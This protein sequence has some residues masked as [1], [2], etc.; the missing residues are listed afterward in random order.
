MA[1]AHL[2]VERDG[3]VLTITINRPRV[4]NALSADAIRELDRVMADA[5]ADASV[6]AVVLTGAGDRA[7]AAGADLRELSAYTP[8]QARDHAREVQAIFTRIERLGTPVIAAVNGLALGG[9]CE[10]A[11]SCAIRIA[12]E[13]AAFGQPEIN[14]AI[15][16]GYGGSSRLPRLVGRGAALDMLLTGE[17]IGARRAY[18]LGLV[19]R[20]VAADLLLAEARALAAS[21][22]AKPAVATRCLLDAVAT[23]ADA[24][25]GAAQDYEAAL[26]GLVFATDDMR[27]GTRAFLEKRIPTFRGR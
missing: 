2:L 18:E 11:L 19:T 27:E 14:L 15:I 9:G 25:I 22:A 24:S 4:L 7:F 17:S 12:A 5:D 8:V 3:S 23:A 20:V 10:L 16:P 1:P 21:L 26:F 6:G 13:T